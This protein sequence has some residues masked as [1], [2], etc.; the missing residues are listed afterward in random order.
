[1]NE[2]AA[3]SIGVGPETGIGSSV[4]SGFNGLAVKEPGKKVLIKAGEMR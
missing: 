2:S 3:R 4:T 1:M